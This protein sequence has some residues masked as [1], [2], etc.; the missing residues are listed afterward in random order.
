MRFGIWDN[1]DVVAVMISAR[2]ARQVEGLPLSIRARLAKIARALRAWPRGSMSK[3]C[4]HVGRRL[5]FLT[6]QYEILFHV[7]GNTLLFD[8]VGSN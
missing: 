3:K 1:H 6:G 5:R 8:Q 7:T 2:A 4:A